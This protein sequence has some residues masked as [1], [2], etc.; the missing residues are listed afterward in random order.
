MAAVI[1]PARLGASRL[2]GKP[3]ELLGALPIV[4]RV[5]RQAGKAPGVGRVAVATDSKDIAQACA[6]HQVE[7]IMT[8]ADHQSG[9][10]RVAEA[11]GHMGEEHIVNVQGDEPFIDPRDVTAVA[12]ALDS[13]APLVS[14]RTAITDD[15]ELH[16]PS[17]V[18]VV[19]DDSDRAMYFSR[20]PI[21]HGTIANRAHRHIGVYGYSVDTLR[22]WTQ[23]PMHELERAE[24]LE[25]LRALAMGIPITMITA[26]TAG[27]GIDT[28]EDLAWARERFEE[29]GESVFP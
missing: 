8:R 25:Q 3:L 9:T 6:A 15:A 17:V 12:R 1:I 7:S 20:A 18:K 29:L 28:P 4:V 16:S 19:C 5:A 27:R 21:P 24:R 2:P 23:A 14:L 26:Y 22:R 13:G 11:A 10:D